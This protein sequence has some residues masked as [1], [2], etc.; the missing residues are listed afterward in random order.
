[1]TAHGYRPSKIVGEVMVEDIYWNKDR[2]PEG[3]K[4]RVESR[5]EK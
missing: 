2:N 4:K 1:M 5:K 3:F